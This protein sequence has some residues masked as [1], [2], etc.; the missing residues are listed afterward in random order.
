M[1]LTSV[2]LGEE[3]SGRHAGCT[4]EQGSLSVN[5]VTPGRYRLLVRPSDTGHLRP[6][7]GLQHG[8]R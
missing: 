5:G 1:A 4:D 7:G 3:Q 6:G 8:H 2:L